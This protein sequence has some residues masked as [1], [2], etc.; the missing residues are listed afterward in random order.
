MLL[1]R[2]EIEAEMAYRHE[3]RRKCFAAGRI[4]GGVIVWFFALLRPGS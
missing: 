3:Q 1:I 4:S 2:E